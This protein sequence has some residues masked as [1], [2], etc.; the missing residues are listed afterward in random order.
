MTT[1]DR[2]RQL[3]DE[4]SSAGNE[5]DANRVVPELRD[6]IH[7]HFENLRLTGSTKYPFYKD[8]MAAD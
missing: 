1:E 7:E 8:G 6:A 2:I 4:V 5:E 3:C